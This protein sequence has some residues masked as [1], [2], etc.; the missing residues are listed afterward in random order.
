MSA[1]ILNFCQRCSKAG[2]PCSPVQV[3]KLNSP[4]ELFTE[5]GY[6]RLGDRKAAWRCPE[7]KNTL[8]SPVQNKGILSN[9]KT[10]LESLQ[11]QLLQ[12]SIKLAPL[13]QL[14]E[15]VKSIKSEIT[16]L[17]SSVSM[18]HDLIANF[19]AAITSLEQRVKSV[20]ETAEAIPHLQAK[21]NSITEELREK[22]Q[23]ART[24]N[25]EVKGI[26]LK[27]KENLYEIIFKISTVIEHPINKDDINYIARIPSHYGKK[28]KSI[29]VSFHSRYK[30]EDFV[31]A[32]RKSKNLTLSKLGFSGS[33]NV[34]VNDH[35]TAF[36]KALLNKTKLAAKEANF[37][38][39]W[40]KHCKILVRK[41]STSQIL[42]VKT[43]KDLLKII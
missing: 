1:V 37:E 27:Q 26:P 21:L 6:R 7:C 41:N 43:E 8:S 42:S 31:A 33:N 10:S 25:I 20:E 18:A 4:T 19:T 32:S 34:F 16:N 28:E 23:W 38:Y 24:N 11:D 13:T 17:Q 36:N 30:K 22:D 14:V 9:P 39:V 3:V 15:D 5:H 35:L 29:V 40:V 2:S 12:I